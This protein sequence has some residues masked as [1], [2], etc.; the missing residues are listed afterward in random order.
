MSPIHLPL[1]MIMHHPLS[2]N[3]NSICTHIYG[4]LSHHTTPVVL[5]A[6]PYNLKH[7]PHFPNL[8]ERTWTRNIKCF[9]PQMR[10]NRSILRIKHTLHPLPH[11]KVHFT[12][13]K[14]NV[15]TQFVIH[16]PLRRFNQLDAIPQQ[17]HK[18]LEIPRA[19]SCP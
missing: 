18:K 3:T 13:V 17:R 12:I 10:P 1:L 14:I 19:I 9:S 4:S 11:P 6:R 5:F 16:F 7:F 15:V 2:F 8:V